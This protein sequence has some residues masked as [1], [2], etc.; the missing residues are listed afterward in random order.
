MLKRTGHSK[1]YVCVDTFGGFVDTHFD[2]DEMH[3]TPGSA[4][5]F[6][7]DNSRG[8]VQRLLKHYG[9]EEIELVRGDIATIDEALLPEQI[10]V[11]LLDVDL[12][13]PTY[14]CL[15]RIY[16]RLVDGGL[17]LVDDC[18]EETTWAGARVAYSR[19]VGELDLPQ[20][21]EMGMGVIER[22]PEIRVAGSA[23][24]RTAR[25]GMGA[26]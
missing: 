22:H 23:G 5:R 14:E 13:V 1:R 19:F 15:M 8:V 18:P 24:S 6:F 7:S 10:A 16:P 26:S 25:A 11:C 12:D 20:R 21:Y 9:C 4:R 2:R 3:G 17:I